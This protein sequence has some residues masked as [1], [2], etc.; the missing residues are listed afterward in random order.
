[1]T[2]VPRETYLLNWPVTKKVLKEMSA[3]L[4]E[5]SANLSVMSADLRAVQQTSKHGHRNSKEQ[6]G[7]NKGTGKK[8]PLFFPEHHK[9]CFPFSLRLKSG[10][11]EWAN[12]L[13]LFHDLVYNGFLKYNN[14][15]N[16]KKQRFL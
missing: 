4:G 16:K 13:H 9:R 11:L 14:V 10:D 6:G 8:R 3:D 12:G 7:K 2:L 15:E 5:L 1:M